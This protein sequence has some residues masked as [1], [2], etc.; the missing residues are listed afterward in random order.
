MT[1]LAERIGRGDVVIL[2]GA[3]GTELERRGAPMDHHAWSAAAI[4]THPDLVRQCHE[5][6]IR[7]GADVII[8]NTFAAVRHVLEGAGL[9]A[10]TG[11]LNRRAVELAKEA[12]SRA[13]GGRDVWI[14]GSISSYAATSDA[15]NLPRPAAAAANFREQ[16]ELLAHGGVDLIVLEMMRDIEY[17]RLALDAAVATKLPVWVG[18]TCKF[19]DGKDVVMR[20]YDRDRPFAEVIG[21]VMRAGGSLAAVMHS[22]VDVTDPAL[23]ILLE[24]WPGPVAVY[25]ESGGWISPHWQFVDVIPVQDFVAAARRWVGK[26]VQIVGGCCGLGPEHIRPLKDA[27]PARIAKPRS[28]A[29]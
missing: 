26:G 23:D 13:S 2:D 8:T 27:L 6:Y 4:A 12:R 15:K 20:G 9:G 25:P 19:A 3:M 1:T 18:F 5:D 28:V 29:P 10:R 16:A 21:P 22:K 14:A 11:E 17:C 7:A 24:Q